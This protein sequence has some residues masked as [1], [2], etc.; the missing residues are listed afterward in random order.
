LGV[1]SPRDETF[2]APEPAIHAGRIAV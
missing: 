2:A 1:S